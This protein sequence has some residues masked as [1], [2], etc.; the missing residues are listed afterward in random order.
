VVGADPLAGVPP[1]LKPAAH[2]ALK[3]AWPILG[4]LGADAP[5]GVVT[6][7]WAGLI[8]QR[9]FEYARQVIAGRLDAEATF[10]F[11]RGFLSLIEGDI[12]AARERFRQSVREPPP[13]WGL[14]K[15]GNRYALGYLQ[16]I[17]AAERER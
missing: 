13:N 12:P 10:F 3:G 2:D 15:R 14:S 11:R 4:M 5:L 6:G 16:L 7:Y 17:E 1:G 8:Q 9:H